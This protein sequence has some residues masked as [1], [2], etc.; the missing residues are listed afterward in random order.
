V[1]AGIRRPAGAV[2]GP[3]AG[4]S[5]VARQV[6]STLL[7]RG[8][9][10][11]TSGGRRLTLRNDALRVEVD[12]DRGAELTY[13]G[14]PAGANLL[15]YA[16][17][18]APLRASRSTS[19]G[20]SELD[21]L[22]EYRGGWQELFPNA[23]AECEVLGVSL[24]FHG[25]VSAARWELLAS[26]PTEAVLRSP[27]RLP[28]VVERRMRIDAS[29]PVLLLEEEIEN[30]SELEIPYLWGHHPAFRAVSGSHVD[31]PPGPLEVHGGGGFELTDVRPGSRGS[32]P[33]A[34][35]AGE[36][37]VDLS[38][39]PAAPVERLCYLP[40]RPAG[41]AA[42]RNLEVPGVALAWDVAAFPHVWFWQQIGGTGFPW[43]G[44]S[45]IT[46]IEPQSAWPKDGLAAAI[47]R[48]R[49]RLLPPAARTS[50]WLT[51]ALL[52]PSAAP[53]GGV[54]RD[55]SLSETVGSYR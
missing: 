54:E 47:A 31:L 11:A 4:G 38:V 53:V 22:S 45:A 46:A 50:A 8:G 20:S 16:D 30:E 25:E 51:V 42:I 6:G 33:A 40:E 29:R 2:A 7:D 26:S 13:L 15:Y 17:W 24:P 18:Q 34:P 49:A 43:Y 44:R 41:W 12:L 36:G 52:A 19:Y 35:G 5:R 37:D 28:I 32:W 1:R 27:A 39:I 3:A 9:L 23:G 21:W 14:P 48:G 10:S 55:G